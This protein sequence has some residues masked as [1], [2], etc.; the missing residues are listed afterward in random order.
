[1]YDGRRREV[2]MAKFRLSTAVVLSAIWALP[3]R[4][5]PT[6]APAVDELVH[7][8]L[9]NRDAGA[10]FNPKSWSKQLKTES[11]NLNTLLHTDYPEGIPFGA[12]ATK[13]IPFPYDQVKA[14]LL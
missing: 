1:M 5:A 6:P 13:I 7:A 10:E 9:E 12:V 3:L 11:L 8:V 14:L 2:F 4:A